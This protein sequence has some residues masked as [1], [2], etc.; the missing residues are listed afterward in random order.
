VNKIIRRIVTVIAVVVGGFLAFQLLDLLM[1]WSLYSWFFQTI[2][3]LSGMPDTLNGAFSIWLVAITLMLLPIFFSVL[4]WKRDLKKV[5]LVVST[6]SAW[7][8]I[9]YFI[10]LPQ[11]GR[12]FNPMTGQTMYSYARTPDGKIDLFPLGYKFHPRYGI[13]LEL[14]TPEVVRE[15]DRKVTEAIAA[16]EREQQ[17][18][19]AEVVAAQERER[20]RQANEAA[21]AQVREREEREA[22]AK[23]QPAQREQELAQQRARVKEREERETQVNAAK[24]VEETIERVDNEPQVYNVRFDTSAGDFV[25]EVHRAWAPNGADRFYNLVKTGYYN[26]V[27]FFRV[28]DNFVV[29]FGINGDSAVN[30]VWQTAWIQDD[31]VKQSN[32]RGYISFAT[33]GPK[34]NT[35]TTQVFINFKDNVFLDRLSVPFGK[36][37]SGIDIVDKLY[38]GY[39]EGA[40]G[41]QGPNQRRVQA[42]GNTYLTKD[43]PRLDYI[44][45]ATIESARR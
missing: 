15:M 29:Q 18:Q 16:K 22:Q 44:K 4:F 36:V 17:R 2:R 28:I 1:V 40:P 37:T 5:L 11:E 14:M 12:F 9:V 26:N 38:S 13:K 45:K 31:P 25:I 30:A 39:G 8:V 33:A 41:G 19:E 21:A 27:R 23:L 10:S 3:S 34:P 42:E 35:R 7:L 32:K 20:Q 24:T 6:V 43:F